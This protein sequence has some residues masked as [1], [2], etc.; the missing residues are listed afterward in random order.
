MFTRAVALN[1]PSTPTP[2]RPTSRLAQHHETGVQVAMKVGRTCATDDGSDFEEGQTVKK[3]LLELGRQREAD[4]GW[5]KS[6][7]SSREVWETRVTL[8]SHPARLKTRHERCLLCTGPARRL[9][10]TEARVAKSDPH[11]L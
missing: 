9:G 1:D 8:R 3:P 4:E 2:S 10:V 5:V 7:P 6:R 11:L